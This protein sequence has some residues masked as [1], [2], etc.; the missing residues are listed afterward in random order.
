[1]L[2]TKFYRSAATDA[3]ITDADM[4]KL[5]DWFGDGFVSLLLL[6]GHVYPID[7]PDLDELANVNRP[8]AI[9]VLHDEHPELSVKQCFDM[10]ET[11]RNR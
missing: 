4:N 10:I 8:A 5:A 11:I 1:M 7:T 9:T 3:I 6:E 2:Y